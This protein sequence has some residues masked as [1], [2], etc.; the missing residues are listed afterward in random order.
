MVI[1]I[2]QAKQEQPSKK[3]KRPERKEAI[4]ERIISSKARI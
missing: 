3:N 2:L 4:Q 1:N